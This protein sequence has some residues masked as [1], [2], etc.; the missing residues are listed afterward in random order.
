[1]AFGFNNNR[2][3]E[4]SPFSYTNTA[5][6]ILPY[7]KQIPQDPEL[8]AMYGYVKNEKGEFISPTEEKKMSPKEQEDLEKERQRVE[9]IPDN[10]LTV[11]ELKLKHGLLT[12]LDTEGGIPPVHC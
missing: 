2:I 11:D 8:A 1:M 7:I 6:S 12:K 5:T 4:R 9:N 3:T 10:Q